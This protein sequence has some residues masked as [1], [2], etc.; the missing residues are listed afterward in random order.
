M[1]TY[2]IPVVERERY[3]SGTPHHKT[4]TDS[5]GQ[6]KVLWPI[7]FDVPTDLLVHLED[8]RL[9]WI[10]LK[11]LTDHGETVSHMM[12]GIGSYDIFLY[13]GL[14]SAFRPD[15]QPACSDAYRAVMAFAER[16][17]ETSRFQS[18]LAP[19]KWKT[20]FTAQLLFEQWKDGEV[21]LRRLFEGTPHPYR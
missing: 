13:H 15:P 9:H 19:G 18:D 8:R 6:S 1:Q 4:V 11:Y 12:Q 10:E 21:F 5:R 2:S 16:L 17:L 7:T 3:L 20:I 14:L